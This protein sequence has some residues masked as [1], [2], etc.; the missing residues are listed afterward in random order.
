M[1]RRDRRRASL[2]LLE[3]NPQIGLLD[4]TGGAPELAP[5]FRR[6][7]RERAPARPARDRPLQ[8][9]RAARARPGGPGRSSSRRSG[10]RSSPA[11]R[12]TAP[13]TS[14]RSAAP[15]V[16]EKSIAALRALNALGYGAPGVAAA[17]RPGL[18]PGRRSS[19]R[20]RRR[21]SR[22]TTARSSASA[23]A[24][25][26][27]ACS[28]SRTCRSA[29]SPT[30]LARDGRSGALHGAAGEPLQ[31]R[32][33]GRAHVPRPRERRATTAGSTTA[34]STRCSSCRSARRASHT[35]WDVDD[36]AALDGRADRDRSALL[37]LHGGRRLELR[38]R[39]RLSRCGSRSSSRCSTRR[40]RIGRAPGGA[41]LAVGHRRG[42][43]R[44][45]R[46]PRRHRGHRAQ[47][48]RRARLER[49]A[50]PG[51]ADERGRAR[52]A[53]RRAALPAR[54]RRR[55]R[56]TP[57]PGGARAGRSRRRGGRVPRPHPSP[58]SVA[59]WLGPLLRLADLRSRVTRL[60]YGDQAVFV[61]RETFE[62]VGG[63]PDQPLMED[64]E[65]ARRLR[66]RRDASASCPPSCRSRDG[67]SSR[68]R[69]GRSSR[70]GS[71][72]CCTGS[73]CRRD[74]SRGSME[75]RAS[76]RRCGQA[77]AAQRCATGGST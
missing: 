24:S 7:V 35:I 1:S 12:A 6:L 32:D 8:P 31:P 46:Q 58:T 42:R 14:T 25:R 70:C 62:R 22:P 37:R 3:R 67:A 57:R 64:V 61:R 11:C 19:C 36:L 71:S 45:R 9:D 54:R 33:G 4:V 69:C 16:F 51:T 50:R 77:C 29:A 15:G 30:Q 40:E 75:A 23:S 59:N 27:T 28:R 76:P 49:A 20:R 52:G 73:A 39:A 60:P 21:S 38:R 48:A 26:S 13:R 5:C 47:R 65:L 44:R 55:C 10:S 63:F 18:Q 2:E 17:P 74:S 56:P 66:R 34:T 68:G 41:A 72:R 53:G 43:G